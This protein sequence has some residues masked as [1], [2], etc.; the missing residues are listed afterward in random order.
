LRFGGAGMMSEDLNVGAIPKC[1]PTG[2]DAGSDGPGACGEACGE[3]G[4][5][6]LANKTPFIENT[7]SNPKKKATFITRSPPPE[8]CQDSAAIARESPTSSPYAMT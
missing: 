7:F 3:A 1:L 2:G 8:A 4:A 5:G 6:H